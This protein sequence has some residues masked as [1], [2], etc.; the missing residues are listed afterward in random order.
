MPGRP[1][2]RAWTTRPAS[3]SACRLTCSFPCARPQASRLCVTIFSPRLLF[4]FVSSWPFPLLHLLRVWPHTDIRRISSDLLLANRAL[5]V[6][7]ADAAALTARRRIDHRVDQRRLARIHRRV[8]GALEFVRACR[9]DANAAESFDHLVVT[10]AFDENRRRRIRT[11]RIDV[12]AAVN[13]VVVEDDDADRQLVAA[14]RL[15][16]HSGEAEGTVTLDRKH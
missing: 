11:G 15:D 1:A 13:A 6:E 3:H 16:L 7:V 5:R 9:V 10:R 12:G 2:R 8:H 14:D 4:S